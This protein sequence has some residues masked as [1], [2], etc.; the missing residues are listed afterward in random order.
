MSKPLWTLLTLFF[1]AVLLSDSVRAQ[2]LRS[3]LVLASPDDPYFSLAEEIARAENLTLVHRVDDALALNPEFLLWVAAPAR[4]TDRAL[5]DFGRAL[6]ARGASVS[7]GIIS[8][9]SIEQARALW[10]RAAHVRGAR[11]FAV[12]GVFP[13]AQVFDGR[14]HAAHTNETQ[15]L[16][17]E[18]FIGILQQADYLT[19][20][21]HGGAGHLSLA[22]NVLLRANDI[23]ALPPVV[24]ST[25][26]CQTFRL[27]RADSI[28]L[29][30]TDRGAAAYAGFVFSPNE[31]FVLGEFDG[32]SFRY[33]WREFPIGHVMQVQTRGTLRGFAAFPFYFLLGDPRIA[34]QEQPPYTLVADRREDA[35]RVLEFRD[36]PAGVVPVRIADGA[37]YRFVE[38]VGIASV[39]DDDVFYNARAQATNIG[40]DKFLLFKHAGGDFTVRLYR[41]TPLWWTMLTPL[42]NAF[43]GGLIFLQPNG[44][45]FFA[46][47]A[48]II[49]W[50]I[51]GWRVRRRSASR[52][53]WLRALFIGLGMA[54]A[55]GAYVYLR[56]E[57]VTLN[58]KP[59][60]FDPLS[61]IGTF[62]LFGGAA[63]WY[64]HARSWQ[65]R[66]FALVWAVAPLLIAALFVCVTMFG[67]NFLATQ[68]IG[69]GY[70]N[71][72]LALIPLLA[73]L[74]EVLLCVPLFELARG[75][76]KD[77]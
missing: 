12:N 20:T 62:V 58:E 71:Y 67:I 56:L 5:A 3:T 33:T 51:I 44:G 21:G 1:L 65:G 49:A 23:P 72:T 24:I 57:Q 15:P 2:I 8:G 38:I 74:G 16:T 77:E 50:L 52:G 46:L 59:M 69:A 14:I 4:L 6:H 37:R 64:L 47:G 22:P 61:L 32:L 36:A 48:G 41:E 63:F 11:A 9:S 13:S 42:R 43:D 75:V 26:S 34:L 73:A 35:Y 53:V 66:V 54:M 76:T 18:T 25:A 10:Q 19:F 40:A 7:V 55:H 28:A 39:S 30:F 31:G 68:Q 29:A 60:V 27:W 70:Y 17:K 45:A